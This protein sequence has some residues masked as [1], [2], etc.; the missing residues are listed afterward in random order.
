MYGNKSTKRGLAVQ[1]IGTIAAA[2]ICIYSASLKFCR[3]GAS[4]DVLI[5]P[6]DEPSWW[7]LKKDVPIGMVRKDLADL[8]IRMAEF[9]RIE[10]TLSW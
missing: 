1:L 4:F 6:V 10:F 8:R 7:A 9:E 5:L 3:N 2:E